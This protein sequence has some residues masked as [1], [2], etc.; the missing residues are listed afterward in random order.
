MKP[1]R[2]PLSTL[3]TT[4]RRRTIS[5]ALNVIWAIRVTGERGNGERGWAGGRCQEAGAGSRKQEAGLSGAFSFAICHLPFAIGHWSLVISICH[6]PFSISCGFV[7]CIRVISWTAFVWF[8]GSAF[9]WFRGSAFVWFRGSVFVSF[10]GSS[11]YVHRKDRSTKS[12]EY[13][14]TKSH[15]CR[16]TKRHEMG[17][18]K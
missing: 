17:N 18:R 4:R 10:R 5:T 13:R 12:H 15:E 1:R 7:D 16:A 9:V 2:Q 11:L 6:F 14:A 3:T 8:R